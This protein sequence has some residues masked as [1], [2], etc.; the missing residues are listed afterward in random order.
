MK[1][2]FLYSWSWNSSSVGPYPLIHLFLGPNMSFNQEY[3][4]FFYKISYFSSSLGYSLLFS[5]SSRAV[6]EEDKSCNRRNQWVP[7]QRWSRYVFL[8]F[9]LAPTLPIF[10][11]IAESYSLIYFLVPR[12]G[13]YKYID[14]TSWMLISAAAD[15]SLIHDQ[16][17][18]NLPGTNTKIFYEFTDFFSFLLL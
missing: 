3:A 7:Q 17:L 6:D 15:E 9:F 5:F 16:H 8:V 14:V 10:I 4:G 12:L 11:V 2:V 13:Y 18:R 1:D